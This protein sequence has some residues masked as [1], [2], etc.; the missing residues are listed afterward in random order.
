MIRTLLF[1]CDKV[2][3]LLTDFQ[4][5]SLPPLQA[6][7]V[8]VHLSLCRGC[9]AFLASL[10]TLP[11][12]LGG[13]PEADSDTLQRILARAKACL[14]KPHVPAIPGPLAAELAAGGNDLLRLQALTHLALAEGRGEPKAPHL[15]PEVLE[16]L[17]PPDTWH[18]HTL[19]LGGARWT[20]LAL[21]QVP[22]Q[23]LLLLVMPSRGRF[24]AHRHLGSESLLVLHGGLEDGQGV[25]EPGQWRYYEK[26]HAPHA[27]RAT[28][29]GCWVLVR[30]DAG[31][32]RLEGW[33]G[34]IQRLLG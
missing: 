16:K 33:R 22:A 30:M 26:G 15:P 25:A 18:W 7:R 5:G 2:T 20:R 8:R 23:E 6:L 24:P 10:R 1:T 17:P 32:V 28:E 13:L 27:P 12:Y 31:A 9:Q 34:W 11:R 19:G 29:E 14:G 4:E 3:D 21:S